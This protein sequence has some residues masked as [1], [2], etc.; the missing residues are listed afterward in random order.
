MIIKKSKQAVLERAW[1]KGNPPLPVWGME[2]A[3]DTEE[4]RMQVP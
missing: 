3:T 4:H 2:I 1:R